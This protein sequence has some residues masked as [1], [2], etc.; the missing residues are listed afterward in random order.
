[1]RGVLALVFTKLGKLNF[2]LYQLA[3]FAAVVV[4]AVALV[5]A[6]FYSVFG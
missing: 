6:Q 2:A 4:G 5:T 1:M 3:I